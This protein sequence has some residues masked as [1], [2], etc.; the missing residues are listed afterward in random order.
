MTDAVQMRIFRKLP[1]EEALRHLKVLGHHSTS[2]NV[3][4]SNSKWMSLNTHFTSMQHLLLMSYVSYS[5]M[6]GYF[7]AYTYFNR[8][9]YFLSKKSDVDT[10]HIQE[11]I[12]QCYIG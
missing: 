5:L 4:K 3:Y 2:V 6:G 7:Q 9:F 8:R 12:S 11:L 10:H 1:S